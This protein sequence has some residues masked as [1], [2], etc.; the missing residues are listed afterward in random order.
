[1]ALKI[2]L[3]LVFAVVVCAQIPIPKRYDGFAQGSQS[4]PI[5]F[6]VFFDLLCP[7][8]AKSAPVMKQLLQYYNVNSTSGDKMHFVFHTFPLIFHRNAYYAATGAH[9]IFQSN[10]S[11]KI[12]RYI[13]LMF[14]HQNQFSEMATIDMSSNQIKHAI[15]SLVEME[16]GFPSAD[17]LKGLDDDDV[18]MNTRIS[19]KYGASRSL[20][21]TPNYFVNGIQVA[22]QSTWTLDDWR[23]VLDPL[24]S[25]TD[26][27]E[28]EQVHHHQQQQQ[29]QQPRRHHAKAQPRSPF[30]PPVCPPG[31]ELC[32]YLPG[33]Y[34]CCTPG[35]S[36]LRNVGCRC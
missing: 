33:Q 13:D 28:L 5:L 18:Q 22:G 14:A 3:A 27:H 11:D 32:E 2:C 24:L 10:Q 8:C 1:M 15:A 12:W 6:E 17:F 25:A 34:Q 23:F 4:A 19:W 21:G 7:F 26:R 20:S 35:E 31:T 9:V 29:Q 16:L 36:C 30:A